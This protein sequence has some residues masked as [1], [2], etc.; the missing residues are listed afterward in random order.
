MFRGVAEPGQ[1]WQ[2]YDDAN[3]TINSDTR[4]TAMEHGD[5]I[6]KRGTVSHQCSTNPSNTAAMHGT[7]SATAIHHE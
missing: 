3:A 2:V 7:G 4:S 1:Q 5:G 6:V